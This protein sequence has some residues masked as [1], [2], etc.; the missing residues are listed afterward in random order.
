MKGNLIVSFLFG[1]IAGAAGTYYYLTKIKKIEYDVIPPKSEDDDEVEESEEEEEKEIFDP[2]E[3]PDIDLMDYYKQK[4]ED[5]GEIE[6]ID[7]RQFSSAAERPD[8]AQ[9]VKER[10]PMKYEITEE[11]FIDEERKEQHMDTAVL[12]VYADG[13]IVDESGGMETVYA[14]FEIDDFIGLDLIKQFVDDSD[15]E[16]MYVRNIMYGTDYELYKK[17]Q[18]WSEMNGPNE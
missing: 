13:A 4:E 1:A 18:K 8:P 10:A 6:V 12:A 16:S 3:V 5:D 2:E 11:E 7:Y 17:D 9:V 15:R 14:D